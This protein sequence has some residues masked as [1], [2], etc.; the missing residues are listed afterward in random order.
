MPNN[1]PDTV[2]MYVCSQGERAGEQDGEPAD[3]G[4]GLQ[5]GRQAPVRSHG[6][7][8]HLQVIPY[9]YCPTLCGSPSVHRRRIKTE[10]KA[11]VVA[12]V[13]GKDFIQLLAA[14]AVLHKDDL[15][16]G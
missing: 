4:G 15:N 14:L 12:S 11:K 16:I 8:P 9:P 6:Q 13:W 2:D 10:A 1:C 3:G 5:G 7:D